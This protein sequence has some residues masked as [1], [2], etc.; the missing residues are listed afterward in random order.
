MGSP[1]RTPVVTAAQILQLE[2][3]RAQN[4]NVHIIP[5]IMFF[6]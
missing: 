6:K 2:R 3:E 1:A 5:R 4:P